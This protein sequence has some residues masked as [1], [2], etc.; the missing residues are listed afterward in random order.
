MLAN[1]MLSCKISVEIGACAELRNYLAECHASCFWDR[2]NYHHKRTKLL[3]R[4]PTAL[5][6][7]YSPSTPA[8]KWCKPIRPICSS[9]VHSG[10]LASQT[11]K[12]INWLFPPFVII[13]KLLYNLFV[14]TQQFHYTFPMSR[15]LKKQKQKNNTI[16]SVDACFQGWETS[17]CVFVHGQ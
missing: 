1:F 5:I 13:S 11:W 15:F 6:Q 4:S 8:R 2:A 17:F 3:W 16:L 14:S 9:L 12:E 7:F 10:Q